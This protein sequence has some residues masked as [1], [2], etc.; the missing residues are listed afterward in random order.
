MRTALIIRKRNADTQNSGMRMFEV[1]FPY[2]NRATPPL[3][4]EFVAGAV[5]PVFRAQADL[6]IPELDVSPFRNLARVIV[7]LNSVRSSPA[8]CG[9]SF[10]AA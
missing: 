7:C 9:G 1:A 4:A 3:S 5:R 10:P 6:L 8:I 2:A